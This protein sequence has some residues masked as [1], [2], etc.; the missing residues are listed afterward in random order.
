MSRSVII[1]A[2]IKR[3]KNKIKTSSIMA[4]IPQNLAF[5]FQYT[6]RTRAFLTRK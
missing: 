2:K 1:R 3:L 4:I 6:I 5:L